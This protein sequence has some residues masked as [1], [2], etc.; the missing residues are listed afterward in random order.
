MGV[1]PYTCS[2]R[3]RCP[4]KAVQCVRGHVHPT[5]TQDLAITSTFTTLHTIT[6]EGRKEDELH[7]DAQLLRSASASES[8]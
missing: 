6:V 3:F 7:M 8:R 5:I 1:L 2:S 4:S